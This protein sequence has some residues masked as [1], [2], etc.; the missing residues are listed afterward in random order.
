MC[1]KCLGCLLF[2]LLQG[3]VIFAQNNELQTKLNDFKA[4]NDF[5]NWTYE[6]LDYANNH[7]EKA[8]TLL[9]NAQK[10]AWRN[11]KTDEEHFAWLNLLSTLGYYQLMNGNILGSIN[12]YESALSFFRKHQLLGY[13]IVEYT[14]KPLS[15]NYTR[16]GDYERALYLQKE[17]IAFQKR[18]SEDASKI[19]TIY[20]NMAISYRSMERLADAHKAIEIGFSLKPDAATQI[21]LNNIQ[22]DVLYDEAKYIKAA[23]VIEDNIRRQKG[24]DAAN[25]Y[26]LMSSYTTAGNIYLELKQFGKA[27]V[28][29]TKALQLLTKYFNHSRVREKA[30]LYNQ[31]GATL[32]AE[33]KLQEAI[34]YANKTLS[35]LGIS[36]SKNQIIEKNIFLRSLILPCL[37]TGD[38]S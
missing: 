15:N 28:S 23:G 26:W 5:S 17:S 8:T 27:K 4:K 34:F 22:A 1:N 31:I 10:T 9:L 13:D 19:A 11:S 32:L 20:C 12:S 3:Y 24:S 33:N 25:A 14:F 7:S 30:N 6:Q 36:N 35:T 37:V 16:L 38:R 18:Y 21:M 29:F 2:I